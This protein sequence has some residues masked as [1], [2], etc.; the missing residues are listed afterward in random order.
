[1]RFWP[2]GKDEEE[3]TVEYVSRVVTATAT[4][5][6]MVRAKLNLVFVEAIPEARG[7]ATAT[8]ATA[9]LQKYFEQGSSELLLGTET[10]ASAAVMGELPSSGHVRSVDVMAIHLVGRSPSDVPRPPR[11]PSSPSTKPVS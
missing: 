7:E 1:M 6:S 11:M 9:I 5:G 2:F 3:A 10:D 4:D 8:A